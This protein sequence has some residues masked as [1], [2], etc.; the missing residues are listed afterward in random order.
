M[1]APEQPCPGLCR[2][3]ALA[4]ALLLGFREKHTT[5]L[6]CLWGEGANKGGGGPPLPAGEGSGS[7]ARAEPTHPI[8][9][10]LLNQPERHHVCQPAESTGTRGHRRCLPPSPQQPWERHLLTRIP[11][12]TVSCC[13][14][15]NGKKRK[16]NEPTAPS[17]CPEHTGDATHVTGDATHATGDATH[18]SVWQ[19]CRNK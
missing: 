3:A 8:P 2:D 4:L 15:R 12:V 6:G 9:P 10:L 18:L 17:S 1:P 5:I 13:Q 14:Q 7:T 16:P 11:N 19:H